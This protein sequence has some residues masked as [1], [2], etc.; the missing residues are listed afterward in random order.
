MSDITNI[1]RCPTTHRSLHLNSARDRLAAE[2]GPTYRFED[3]IARFLAPAWEDD[4]THKTR[5][6]YET[7]GWERDEQGLYT[8]TKA[9]LDTRPTSLNFTRQ[10]IR[11]LNKYFRKGGAYLLDAGSGPI[12]HDEL[13]S[14][15]ERFDKRVCLDLSGPALLEARRKLGDRGIYVQ[16]DL[17][18]LPL[19]TDSM[20]AVL[21]YHV[22]YQIP[23]DAQAQAFRELWR[24]LKPGGV[25]VI[26]Y[27]WEDH[28]L[29]WRLERAARSLFGDLREKQA[30][31]AD[32]ANDPNINH[33]P[34]SRSWFEAQPWPFRYRLDTFRIV[35]NYFLRN[36]VPGRGA[37][38]LGGLMALQTLAPGF[39]GRNGVM[40]T[41]VVRKEQ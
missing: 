20:D 35:D 7:V 40:P 38:F 2:G 36:Y 27:W 39:C 4:P 41:I 18:N 32:A 33:H 13:L 30:D 21:C 23:P 37:T 14:Y 34:L 31:K 6:F 5:D 25:A 24:V 16:G 29:S 1:L 15:G 19:K 9:F 11:R 22:I 8:D 12:A 28:K 3:G 10:C 17:T 26:V